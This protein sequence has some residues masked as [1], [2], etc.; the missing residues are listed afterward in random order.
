VVARAEL[1]WRGTAGHEKLLGPAW[2]AAAW[3]DPAVPIDD[4]A[5]F[6]SLSPLVLTWS[7]SGLT[8]DVDPGSFPAEREAARDALACGELQELVHDTRA[9]LSPQRF[10]GNVVDAVR[11]HGLR[12]PVDPHEARAR[13]CG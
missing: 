4:P 13:F 8:G 9:P 11:L 10:L 1:A 5:S 6:A 3:V 7:G 12:V 2:V